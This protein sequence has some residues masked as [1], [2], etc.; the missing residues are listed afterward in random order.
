MIAKLAGLY[1]PE[2]LDLQG[3]ITYTLS[4]PK[5]DEENTEEE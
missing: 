3:D 1:E 5:I 4:F 2:K